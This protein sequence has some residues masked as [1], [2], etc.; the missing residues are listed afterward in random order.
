[1]KY[2]S[3]EKD[4]LILNTDTDKTSV[5]IAVLPLVLAKLFL[6]ITLRCYEFSFRW[7][8]DNN[9]LQ[10]LCFKNQNYE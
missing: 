7:V 2:G 9:N 6:F 1:M 3:G 4:L 10:Y 8:P 5:T